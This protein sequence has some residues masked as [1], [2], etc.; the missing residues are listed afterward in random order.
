M[1]P[2]LRLSRVALAFL[3]VVLA[4][5]V[6]YAVLGF[7]FLDSLYQTVTTITTV[8][9]REVHP[10]TPAGQV[11]TMVLILVGAGT[12]FYLFGILLEALIEGH[13]R[14]HLERRRMD[15][16]IDR[17]RGHVIVC[18]WGRVG[19]ST[20]QFLQS[21]G[22]TIVVI[23]K[24]PERLRDIEFPHILGDVTEDSV[25][26]AAGIAHAH[27]LIA[28]LDS[29]ADNVYVTLSSRALRADLVIIARA[30]TESSK[31]KLL[32]AG[33]NRAVNPQ[34]I[35]G[36]RMAAFALQ[37]NVAEF[38]DVVMHE[39]A[40]EY[41]IEEIG[42]GAGSELI[43][44]TLTDTALRRNTGALLL[45]LRTSEGRFITNPTDETELH[46][47]DILIV[48]G[49]PAQLDAVRAEATPQAD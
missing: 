31:S 1:N 36:R 18:G 6:G 21:L 39:D 7:G 46:A 16:R 41:R 26:D 47:G 10:L 11:F 12:V 38:L 13:L 37:P 32:R 28:A 22:K 25:L 9:F 42:I 44:R 4:G 8:G 15:R 27:A 3:L 17:M 20:A 29:D 2:L 19:R 35:G 30:R 43:G 34:L 45:A 33:A 40:L 5:T 14:H 49:T 48:L 24:D 23:D